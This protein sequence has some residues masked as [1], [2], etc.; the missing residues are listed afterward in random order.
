EGQHSD[1]NAGTYSFSVSLLSN[2]PPPAL[3]GAPLVIG[4]TIA[5]SLATAGSISNY[6][7][8]LASP[9]TL[10]FD[11]LTNVSFTW[12]LR[13][14]PGLPVNNKGFLNSDGVDGNSIMTL[15]AGQYQLS[16]TG[17]AGGYEFRLLDFAAAIPFTLGNVVSNTL[18]PADS[19][20]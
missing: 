18:A 14:P 4:S 5:G 7:F 6:V 11:A 19:T 12:S 16:I 17:A 13:G 1:I 10:C 3:T 8:T 9:A 20:T 15:P 2:V